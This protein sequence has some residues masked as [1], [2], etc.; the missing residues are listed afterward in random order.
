MLFSFIA[1]FILWILCKIVN[2]FFILSRFFFSFVFGKLFLQISSFSMHQHINLT[3]VVSLFAE[4]RICRSLWLS[5]PAEEGEL[6]EKFQDEAVVSG[7]GI[8]G[9]RPPMIK[10]PPETRVTIVD[11]DTCSTW[12]FLKELF[13]VRE[14]EEGEGLFDNEREVARKVGEEVGRVSLKR[15]EEEGLVDNAAWIAQV[16]AGILESSSFNTLNEDDS[17][18]ATEPRS[19]NV[20][21]K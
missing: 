11:D 10:P 8:N 1:N 12:D 20:S 21:P 17:C 18:T 15:E 14:S 16:V 7:G 3:N 4:D 2:I 6:S 5:G 9:T 19:N 13:P